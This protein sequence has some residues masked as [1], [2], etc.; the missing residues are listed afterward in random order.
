MNQITRSAPAQRAVRCPTKRS[1]NLAKRP[2]RTRSAGL[3]GR[4]A[5]FAMRI[6][7]QFAGRKCHDG[8]ARCQKQRAVQP[9]SAHGVTHSCP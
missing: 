3:A 1:V 5:P 2:P 4:T 8:Q 6:A 7:G 9:A